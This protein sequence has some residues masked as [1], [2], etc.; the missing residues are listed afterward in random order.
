M[1]QSA[2]TIASSE[3]VPA[4][5]VSQ[6]ARFSGE[7]V[8]CNCFSS[9]VIRSGKNRLANALMIVAAA[10]RKLGGQCGSAGSGQSAAQMTARHAASGRRAHQMWSVEIWPCGST[11]RAGRE[12]RCARWGDRLRSGV[13]G[14]WTLAC[15]HSAFT[16]LSSASAIKRSTSL[17]ASS[18][19]S[20]VTCGFNWVIREARSSTVPNGR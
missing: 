9:S 14:R 17:T 12:R 11:S 8:A 16:T 6:R 3:S 15:C 1:P 10:S 19:N 5:R 13:W 2:G 4:D 18:A 20:I 7:A